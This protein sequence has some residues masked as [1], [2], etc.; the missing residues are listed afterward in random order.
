ME[1]IPGGRPV[2][3]AH[4]PVGGALLFAFDRAGVTPDEERMRD[5][6][7]SRTRH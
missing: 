7:Q 5:R 2:P 4:E 6:S 3:A 1:R